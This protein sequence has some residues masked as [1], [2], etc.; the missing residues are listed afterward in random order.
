MTIGEAGTT[1]GGRVRA[2]AEVVAVFLRLGVSAFGGPAAHI[3]FMR[4]EVVRCRRWISEDEFLDLVAAVHLI[5]GPNSTE[6]AIH[7]GLRRAGWRGLLA[8]GLAFILPAFFIVTGLAWVYV[9]Y[10]TTPQV[11]WLL[12]GISPVIVAIVAH[13]A[14]ALTS[15]YATRSMLLVMWFGVL[16]LSLAGVGELL[17]VGAA[18]ALCAAASWMRGRP[19]GLAVAMACA[20]AILGGPAVAVA[21]GTAPVPPT[22][23]RLWWFFLKVGSVLF[24]SGY[25]LVAFLRADLVQRWAW[26]TD[27]QLLDAVAIGQVTPGPLFTTASFIGFLLG[28]WP[29]A[30]IATVAIFLPSFVLVAITHRLVRRMRSSTTLGALLDGVTVASLALMA[31]VAVGLAPHAVVDR[32]TAAIALAS[33]ALLVWGRVSPTWLVGAAAV[34]G[35][36]F[37]P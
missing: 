17:L 10:G 34:A 36:A 31:A 18:G 24:G 4:H 7:L 6:L 3:G 21:A 32:V 27:Q 35:L 8:G 25:V 29:G 1:G 14:G 13:A 20:L 16:A 12:Y 15:R 19:P 26:L 2:V 5:P 22:L 9:A 33:G 37:H 23:E 28:S 11:R 30:V